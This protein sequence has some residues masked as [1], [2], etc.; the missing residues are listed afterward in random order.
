MGGRTF[1]CGAQGSGQ[2]AKICNNLILGASMVAVSEA[3]V[4][5]EALGLS[6][7]ALY[8]VASTSSGSCFALTQNCPVPGPR[9]TSPA[10][11][12]YRPG[13][14]GDLMLKDLRLARAAAAHTG[15]AARLCV[16]ATAQYEQL[17]AEGRGGLDFSGVILSIREAGSAQ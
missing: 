6:A 15:V 8:D 3:F 2:A 9:P 11:N 7:Q 10:N 1:H 17:S 4:L 12:D 5:G 13:F 14:A 16:E